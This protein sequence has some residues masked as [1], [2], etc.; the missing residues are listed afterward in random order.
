MHLEVR[1][2]KETDI[3]SIIGYFL[4][5]EVDFLRG[6]GVDQTKL[7]TKD[8]W[9]ELILSEYHKPLQEKQFY[10]LIWEVDG[11]AVG[12][13]NINKIEFGQSGYMHLHLWDSRS[14]KQGIGTD[15]IKLSIP[16]YFEKFELQSLFCEPYAHNPGP[17][18]VLGKTGFYLNKTY[19]TTPGWINFHQ[20]VNSYE[21]TKKRYLEFYK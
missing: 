7:P 1:E 2:I 15:L 12:H 19:D 9:A 21:L 13:S 5:A 3:A 6:M 8:V 20:T 17:N 11:M 16:H 18:K 10:Y 4:N 14:R